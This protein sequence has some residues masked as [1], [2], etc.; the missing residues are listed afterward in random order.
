MERFWEQLLEVVQEG[1]V[2]P[3]IGE[4][5]LVIPVEGASQLYPYVA[6]RL[7]EYLELPTEQLPATPTLNAV[8]CLHLARHGQL[9]DIYA[10][11]KSIMRA[12]QDRLPIPAPLLKLAA[13]RDFRL[14]VTTTFDSLLERAINQVRYGGQPGTEVIAYAP[15]DVKDLPVE[16]AR[17]P[18]PTVFHLLGRVSAVPDYA[19][20]EED[21]LEFLH[22]LQ[23][24]IKRP[25]LLFDELTRGHLLIIGSGFSDWLARFFIRIAKRERLWL[26]RSKTDVVAD[27][28]IRDDA[29]LVGFLRHFSARTKIFP[30]A[31]VDFVDELHR[32]W[33]ERHPEDGAARAAPPATPADMESG[34]V[35]LSYASED[36]EAVQ[37]IAD[38]LEREG[39]AVWFDREQLEAG[40]AFG[41]KIRSHI[42]RCA[43]FLPIISR[44]V[45][46]P[47]RRFF[48]QEWAHALRVA[49]QAPP[50]MPFIVPVVVDDTTPR[51][52]ALPERFRQLHWESLPQGQPTPEFLGRMKRLFREYQKSVASLP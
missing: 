25:R 28:R 43:L 39:V 7:A 33:G 44:R 36:R 29:A 48:R 11:V 15:Q 52:A 18:R 24:E 19:V 21:T 13:I 51:E 26:A 31:A 9:E 12:E 17:L 41:E 50:N 4:D 42:E 46:T 40:D 16:L 8:A 10:A 20:T 49:D 22:A 38:A 37:S 5:L 14:F 34:A 3:V 35:F 32:R 47:G 2:I 27:G 6:T 23:S 45:L 30:G 1:R